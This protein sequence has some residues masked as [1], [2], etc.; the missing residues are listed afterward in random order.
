M[1]IFVLRADKR[2]EIVVFFI[3][4]LYAVTVY[5]LAQSVFSAWCSAYPAYYDGTGTQ[6]NRYRH[7]SAGAAHTAN[8]S[9]LTTEPAS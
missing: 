3:R 9:F 1:A 6:Q 2:R 7:P 4:E 8:T 5:R